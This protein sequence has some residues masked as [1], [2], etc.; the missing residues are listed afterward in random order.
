MGRQVVETD[1]YVGMCRRV[2]RS[3]GKRVDT[4]A[5]AAF[6]DLR[7]ELELAEAASARALHA[8]G[9]SWTEIGAVMGI[10][11]QAA[12]QRFATPADRPEQADGQLELVEAGL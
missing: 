9:F 2:I 7:R 3:L 6:A 1:K 10:T 8:E 5:L 12:R 11:R 4:E